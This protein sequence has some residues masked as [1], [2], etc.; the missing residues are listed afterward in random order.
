M[1]NSGGV[2]AGP[3]PPSNETYD[4]SLLIMVKGKVKKPMKPDD[5]EKNCQIQKLQAE[6][7]K[8]SDRIKE[9]KEQIDNTQRSGK[10]VGGGQ[11]EIVQQLSSLNHEKAAVVVSVHLMLQGGGCVWS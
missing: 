6:I 2:S 5:T 3:A 11:K 10:G 8:R 1:D 4:P 9:I 7:N